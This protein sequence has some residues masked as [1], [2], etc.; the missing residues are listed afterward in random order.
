MV[1]VVAAGFA[2]CGASRPPRTQESKQEPLPSFGGAPTNRTPET[3]KIE[4]APREVDEIVDLWRV[5]IL[6]KDVRSWNAAREAVLAH[7]EQSRPLVRKLAESD[8]SD[9]VRAINLRLLAEKSSPSDTD[10]FADRLRDT[11]PFVRENACWALGRLRAKEYRD[12]L[13]RH[14]SDPEKRV[15]DAARSALEEL[16][17]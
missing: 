6:R 13:R 4:D 12:L 2:Y 9:R 10:F 17:D 7:W 11:S 8:E 3:R 1:L 5:T 15:A 14:A 16:G